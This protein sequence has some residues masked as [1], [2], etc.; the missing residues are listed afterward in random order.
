MEAYGEKSFSI[1]LKR[2]QE[3]IYRGG[4]ARPI[5]SELIQKYLLMI[6]IRFLLKHLFLTFEDDDEKFISL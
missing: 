4:I 2:K 1:R 5:S 6:S 3:Q